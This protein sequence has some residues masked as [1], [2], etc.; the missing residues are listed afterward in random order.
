MSCIVYQVDKKTG[1]KY[2]YE[3][4]SF[5]D[6]DKQQPRS[7][8]VYL[9]KVDPE[10]GEI[11]PKKGKAVHSEEADAMNAPNSLSVDALYQELQ[12]KDEIIANLRKEVKELNEKYDKASDIIKRIR[13]IA[14]EEI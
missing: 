1:V 14:E 4:V 11:I 7:K 2:A 12:E 10:T 5:W 13:T 9:G 6:K 8:R 3:S